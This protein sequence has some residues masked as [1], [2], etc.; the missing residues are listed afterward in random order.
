MPQ[1][2]PSMLVL[3]L[4]IPMLHLSEITL[5]TAPNER[6]VLDGQDLYNLS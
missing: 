3:M 5:L 1:I 2:C 6:V 4:N